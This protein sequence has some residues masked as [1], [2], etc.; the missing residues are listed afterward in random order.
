[1][2]KLLFSTGVKDYQESSKD[3]SNSDNPR[4]KD[5]K[6]KIDFLIELKETSFP[7][8]GTQEYIV[9]KEMSDLELDMF[10]KIGDEVKGWLKSPDPQEYKVARTVSFW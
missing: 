5:V 7:A 9:L 2:S 1:M 4:I 8:C 10:K 6:E 3:W